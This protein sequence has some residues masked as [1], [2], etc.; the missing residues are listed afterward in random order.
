MEFRL[1]THIDR[2]NY[3]SDGFIE[4]Y[5]KWFNLDEFFFL[6]KDTQY[7]KIAKYLCDKG[8][9]KHQMIKYKNSGYI[10]GHKKK[11]QREKKSQFI[12]N[13]YT[14]LYSSQDERIVHP[15]L[16]N[17]IINNLK[18]YIVPRGVVIIQHPTEDVLDVTK[19]ILSQRSYQVSDDQGRSK[20]QILKK[21]I[22]WDS[23]MH[24][25]PEGA[26][27][28]ENIFLVDI[29]KCCTKIALDNNM[30]TLNIYKNVPYFY[31]YK[32]IEEVQKHF[33]KKEYKEINKGLKKLSNAF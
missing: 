21:N 17:Y 14:V 12:K 26:K 29:G 16:R 3:F 11:L 20:P 2:I 27:I 25:I 1:M 4:Y 31:K 30:I 24:K 22:N 6:V 10:A 13:G 8:F 18:N 7:E 23:G 9:A 19:P 33:D 15:D 32:T 5:T 28:D